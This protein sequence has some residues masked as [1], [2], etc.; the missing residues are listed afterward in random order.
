MRYLITLILWR[1]EVGQ[2]RST[3]LIYETTSTQRLPNYQPN[4]RTNYR[5]P[6]GLPRLD[7]DL[8]E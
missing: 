2:V 8:Y 1:R 3:V 4:Y 5:R 7:G 6:P